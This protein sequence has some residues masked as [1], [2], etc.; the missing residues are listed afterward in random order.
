[1]P[2]AAIEEI[3]RRLDLVDVIGQS[4]QLKRSG[5]N[6]KGLCP[7]HSEKTP[8]FYVT[9]ERGT[10]RCFGCGE[11][12]DVF[13]FVQ[14]RDNLE[15][16]EALRI[17]AERAGVEVGRP[18][19]PDPERRERRDRLHAILESAA[20]LYRGTL[21]DAG[22]AATRAYLDRRGVS[23]A[24]IERFGLGYAEPTGRALAQHL[25]R[26]GYGLE[27]AVEAGALGQ[28][29]DGRIYDRF[30]GRV[31]FPIR[32]GEGRMI[33]FGGRALADDQQPKYLNSPQTELFDK[34]GSLYALDQAKAA[35]RSAGRAIVVEGY[36][37]A[38]IAHQHGFANVVA[39][40]GTAITDKHIHELRRQAPEVVLCL[41]A[42]TAGMRAAVRGSDVALGSTVDESPR[43]PIPRSRGMGAFY[44]G[45][46][47]RLR[48]AV[49]PAG[50]DPDDVIR[51]DPEMWTRLIDGALPVVDFV[52]ASLHDRHDL[53]SGDGRREA[54]REAMEII[55][56][57]PDPIERARYIQRLAQL[58]NVPESFLLQTAG[59]RPRRVGAAATPGPPPAEPVRV[60]YEEKLQDLV[61]AL[62]LRGPGDA[63][64]PDPADFE[65]AAHRAILDRLLALRPIEP[66]TFLETVAR[67]LGPAAEPVVERLLR[68]DRE[69]ERLV[70]EVVAK[71]LE[72]RTL[73]LRELRLFRQ[74]Q[75]LNSVVAE[76]ERLSEAEH[77]TYQERLAHI[78]ADIGDVLARQRQ[79]GAVGS[80]SWS[81]RR[82]QEVL[83][84]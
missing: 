76:A 42:D 73:K 51:E 68:V 74:H 19:P 6:F 80:T 50:R 3:K 66:R 70:A 7:F 8:S 44:L 16:P 46:R 15:F 35:I 72:I 4:V 12:G 45:R 14:R 22:G 10:W 57:L 59:T 62:L 48:I 67:D 1:M 23:R 71:E 38:L 79:L 84:G 78:A 40:L 17:L 65:S 41:D 39:T 64:P 20:L 9:P 5:R 21:G 27:E 55:Q 63:A 54:V 30:R 53:T 25:T 34:G 36:M 49:L 60:G 81:A 69:T 82:G 11:G 26:A 75:A 56:E 29:E 58:L 47:T 2:D 24:A 77:R 52:L 28:S 32:D 18:A 61:L 13:T 31:M 43:I 37:D 83:G 33:G